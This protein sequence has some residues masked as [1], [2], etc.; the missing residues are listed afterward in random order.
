[1]LD[2]PQVTAAAWNRGNQTAVSASGW[3]EADMET[4]DVCSK[5]SIWNWRRW[6]P[7]PKSPAP[8]VVLPVEP[9]PPLEPP[10]IG[11]ALGGGFARGVA[12]AGVL[13]VLD[14]AGIPLHCI[15][16]VSAGAIAAAA[17]AS[18]TK[19]DDIGRIAAAMRFCDIARWTI[20]R[21]GFMRTERMDAFLRKV[22]LKFRFEE[23]QIPLGVIA[24][25]LQNGKSLAFR[26]EGDVLLPIR[27]SC[28]YPGIFQ[29]VP[30]KGRLLVDGGVSAEVPSALARAMGATHVI[31]VYIPMQAE[32]MAPGNMF[33]V[34][35]RCF[36]IMH[37]HSQELW[38]KH[39]DVVI[40]PQVSDIG[41]NGFENGR[42]M[43]EAGEAAAR[44]ALPGILKLLES[45]ASVPQGGKANPGCSRLSA[46]FG[47][48]RLAPIG[49]G[50][51]EKRLRPGLA[52]P[53]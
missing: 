33:E 9:E 27:A 50:P 10:R 6:F 29:P 34:V 47:L 30:Y 20:C 22:L 15:T 28:S 21:L 12:H 25:D 40:E 42:R 31:S 16:G 17:Y 4:S 32:S 39:S 19:P 49:Q 26:D 52:A 13:R 14:E 11:L 41:W 7:K 2:H 35:N 36:Q 23:M 46:D 51:I 3:A 44:A 43:I 5:S 37:H 18:G 1:M 8:L 24:T 45:R 53:Q 38:R 48:T